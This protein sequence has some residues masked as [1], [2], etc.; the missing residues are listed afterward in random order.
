MRPTSH[1][2][3][4]VLSA[5][6]L[7]TSCVSMNP[8]DTS[9]EQVQAAHQRLATAF[10]TCDESGFIG[11]YAEDFSFVTSNTRSTV[12]TKDGLK[13]YLAASCRMT[14]NPT[15]SI[16]TQSVRFV[17]AEALVTGQYLFRVPAGG[18]VVDLSQNFTALLVREKGSWKIAAHHISIAP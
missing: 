4:A 16:A 5:L 18:K 6:V 12:R 8:A 14:P 10:S 11:T 1:L 13:A 3:S 7:L 9:A 15:A 2:T 17:G